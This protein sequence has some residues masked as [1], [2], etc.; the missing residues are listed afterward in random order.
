MRLRRRRTTLAGT[1]VLFVSGG[2]PIAGCEAVTLLVVAASH[3]E[4]EACAREAGVWD[5]SAW[6]ED[7]FRVRHEDIDM[8]LSDARGFVWKPG[9]ARTW[10]GSYSWPGR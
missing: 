3:G 5:P 7:A 2:E 10:A 1:G 8:A 6:D 9:H 4:A